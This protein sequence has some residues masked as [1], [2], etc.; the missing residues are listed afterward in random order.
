MTVPRQHS[1]IRLVAIVVACLALSSSDGLAQIAVTPADQQITEDPSDLAPA[2]S[3]LKGAI[4]DSVRPLL[5]EHSMRARGVSAED[6]QRAG[7]PF[8]GDYF[9]S[10]RMP[11][12]WDD[13]DSWSV[14]YVGHPIH[15]AASGF[16]WL[17]H[18]DGAHDPQLG[19][20]REYWASRA[21]ATA[22]AAVYSFQFEFGPLSEASIGNVG[23]R[24]N[25]TGWVDHH[26]GRRSRLHGR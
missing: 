25:T 23:L 14:N 4:T 16:I 18:E 3:T 1:P 10:V 21:R 2:K 26:A 13:G 5:L 12:T 24:P 20:S 19:F 8:F 6:S 7:G 17:D 9:R 15:G 22:W 11:Q